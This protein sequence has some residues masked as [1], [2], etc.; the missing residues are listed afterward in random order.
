M[1]NTHGDRKPSTTTDATPINYEGW[2]PPAI[3]DHHF[4][5]Q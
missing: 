4:R 2:K 3:A 5:R 1:G